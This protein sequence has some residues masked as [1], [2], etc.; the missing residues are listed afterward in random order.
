M[1]ELRPVAMVVGTVAMVFAATMIIPCIVDALVGDPE[2]VDF[3]FSAGITLGLGLFLTAAT[4]SPITRLSMRQ[5]FLLAN[6]LWVVMAL[7]GAL[8]FL[9]SNE[10]MDLT[11]AMFESMSG[12]T[13][14]GA[15]VMSG[16]NELPPGILLW[17][18]LLQFFGGGGI[19]LTAMLILPVLSVGGMQLFRSE[20]SDPSSKT[21]PRIL[22]HAVIIMM[23]YF[24]LTMLA[25][26]SYWL[27]GMTGFDAIGHAMTTL[28][29]GGF[30]THDESIGRYRDPTIQWLVMIFMVLGAL[31]F[32]LYFRLLRGFVRPN[33][34]HDIAAIFNDTQVRGFLVSIVVLGLGM[35]LYLLATTG[36]FP[37]AQLFR[38]I[39]FT[40]ISILTTTGYTVTD[41]GNWSSFLI[42][43]I[44]LM[45][46]FGG[47][48][49]G[50]TTGGLKFFRLH[51][52]VSI[53]RRQ[54]GR[55]LQPHSVFVSRH[56]GGPMQQELS[57]AVMEYLCLYLL[58]Y[59]GLALGIAWT[60]LDPMTAISA[61]AA[62][63][64]N[65]G[66]G[67][68][69]IVGPQGNYGALS[70]EAKWLF[71]AGMLLGRL[72]LLTVFVLFSAHF[73]RE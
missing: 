15:T 30:S 46:L 57:T 28:A 58:T 70:V 20:V 34:R 18:M 1:W 52:L 43:L 72:E 8:P 63:I 50:S 13:T 55:R 41:Y 51:I 66:P 2:W 73:W 9:M 3:A 71:I 31:P 22:R 62:A 59:I 24:G 32:A 33:Q 47:G 14:T 35:C 26:L 40:T 53:S 12:L 61:A 19:V 27:A 4:N 64:S 38:E 11:D 10:S 25:G 54:V 44:L 67:L 36:D 29:T 60:G 5:T 49:A 56:K 65:V 23:V 48:C 16:L 6:L 37:V 21:H 7:F 42:V 69:D 17:R 45:T 68:G 39:F